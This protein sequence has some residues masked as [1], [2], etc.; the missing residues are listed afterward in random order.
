VLLATIA[1]SISSLIAD[2]NLCNLPMASNS[3]FKLQWPYSLFKQIQNRPRNKA[4][5]ITHNS[6][7]KV[8]STWD[9]GKNEAYYLK[10]TSFDKEK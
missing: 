1:H 2:L 8:A 4:Y 5:I 3:Y 6:A 9:E 7:Q 10:I